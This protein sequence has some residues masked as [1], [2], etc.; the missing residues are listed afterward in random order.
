MM[1]KTLPQIHESQKELL[2][3]FKRITDR[4]RRNRVHAVLLVKT[5]HGET[6]KAIA[7][8]LQVDRK[9][10]ERWFKQ[11]EQ[12]GLQA[13]LTSHRHRCGKK[14]SIQGEALSR[15]QE[16]LNR[17]EGFHGYHSICSWLTEQFG[18]VIPY[19]TVYGTV[20]YKLKGSPKVPRKSNV[21]KDAQCEDAFK[22]KSLPDCS[23]TL[24]RQTPNSYQ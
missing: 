10:V 3:L 12:N 17:P 4:E 5:G 2:D 1:P 8:T 19:K 16:Q 23:T 14:P 24:N 15:L 18:L 13:L 21:K 20:A 11:Y 6:R 7:D 22:K 9:T